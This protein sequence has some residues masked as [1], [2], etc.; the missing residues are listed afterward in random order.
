MRAAGIRAFV[1]ASTAHDNLLPDRHDPFALQQFRRTSSLLGIAVKAPFQKLNTLGAQLVFV[2]QLR[3]VALSD[4]VHDGPFI[5]ETGPRSTAS[6][7]LK[8]NATERPDV[9]GAVTAL[10]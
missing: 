5:V 3:W 7:H 6:A 8:D 9:D 1:T 4:V 2:R 10:V